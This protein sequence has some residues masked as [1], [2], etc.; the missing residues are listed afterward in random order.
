MS[1]EIPNEKQIEEL[2]NSI[3]DSILN[4]KTFENDLISFSLKTDV[5]Q[6]MDI[7]D[8]YESMFGVSLI[9]ELKKRLRGDLEPAMIGFWLSPADY[10]CYQIYRATH[11]LNYEPEVIFEI[12]S[13]RPYEL[14]QL[15]KNNYSALYNISLEE[16]LSRVISDD[17]LR[18]ALILLNTER[19]VNPEPDLDEAREDAIT[20]SRTPVKEWCKNKELFTRIFAVKSP[21][22]LVVMSRYYFLI[23]KKILINTVEST[24]EGVMRHLFREILFNVVNPHELFA[25]KLKKAA[26]GLGYS[27]NMLERI[28]ISRCEIDMHLIKDYYE[29][30][31]RLSL[32]EDIGCDTYGYHRKFLTA[33]SERIGFKENQNYDL[34]G[35]KEV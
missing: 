24:M 34:K 11:G 16:E 10:D 9:S 12:F 14:L 2:C 6:R 26:R 4:S 23:A 1:V 29:T 7:C 27:N 33:L 5:D 8:K 32:N 35:V 18:N 25:E 19:R 15:I 22:E 30:T 3:H 13:N 31:F 28:L 21:E 17:I 20:L